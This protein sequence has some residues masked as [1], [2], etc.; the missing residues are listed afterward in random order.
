MYLKCGNSANGYSFG[1]FGE[2][3]ASEIY[4]PLTGRAAALQEGEGNR[5]HPFISMPISSVDA[6]IVHAAGP[7]F[8]VMSKERRGF[9]SHLRFLQAKLN[10]NQ[11]LSSK[12]NLMWMQLPAEGA[13]KESK[14]E[15][16]LNGVAI[17][18]FHTCATIALW[19]ILNIL[20]KYQ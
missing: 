2:T 17:Y 3:V 9:F 11:R 6:C 5:P 13:L 19:M 18:D 7:A 12:K 20:E 16:N 14:R 1:H 15:M 10:N 4:C 8:T